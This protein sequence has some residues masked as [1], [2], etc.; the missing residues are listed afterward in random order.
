M[1]SGVISGRGGSV[2]VVGD[3]VNVRNMPLIDAGDGWDFV[4]QDGLACWIEGSFE[5]ETYNEETEEWERV[6]PLEVWWR[7]GR[8]AFNRCLRDEMVRASG[9]CRPVA[10]L[11]WG[12]EWQL[13]FDVATTEPLLGG[14][15]TGARCVGVHGVVNGVMC[16]PL[17][18][19]Y[20][21]LPFANGQYVGF[22]EL[23]SRS[24]G[25]VID[26]DDGGVS[27]EPRNGNPD[28]AA[29]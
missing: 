29:V 8:V 5:F 1:D 13:T 28:E 15:R 20:A 19:V 22:G 4:T 26:F 2:F 27:F 11:G 17:S 18:P 3:P 6:E 24:N 21:V 9:Q 10:F 25:V 12:S 16:P 7:S 23:S 14:E